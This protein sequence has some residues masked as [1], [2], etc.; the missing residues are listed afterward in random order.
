M[1]DVNIELDEDGFAQEVWGFAPSS[2]SWSIRRLEPPKATLA[3]LRFKDFN[4]V[5]SGISKRLNRGELWKISYDP[6][7]RWVRIGG[8]VPGAKAIE[9]SP[10]LM[11]VLSDDMLIKALWINLSEVQ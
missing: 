3:G 6:N 8:D 5:M 11:A 4:S 7:S 10:G 2:C 1:N 9:F